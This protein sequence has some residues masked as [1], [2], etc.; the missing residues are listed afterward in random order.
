MNNPTAR[1]GKMYVLIQVAPELVSEWGN[2]LEKKL[3]DVCSG[4]GARW[5]AVRLSVSR[6]PGGYRARAELAFPSGARTRFVI[7]AVTLAEL[8]DRLS[9]RLVRSASTFRTLTQVA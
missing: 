9:D 5:D 2:R 3:H 4:L 6:Y 8:V 1:Q 7:N